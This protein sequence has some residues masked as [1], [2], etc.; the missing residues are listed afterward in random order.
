MADDSTETFRLRSGCDRLPLYYVRCLNS[1]IHCNFKDH[2]NK[3]L[4]FL[5]LSRL[6]HKISC[7][8]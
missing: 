7:V 2:R 5:T 6:L 3:F 4:F 1:G 8:I